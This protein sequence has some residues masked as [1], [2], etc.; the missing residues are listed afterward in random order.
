MKRR[1]FLHS[2]N[3][4]ALSSAIHGKAIYAQDSRDGKIVTVLGPIDPAALGTTLPHEHV[5]VDF[6]G[7]DQISEGRYDR[8]EAFDVILP[9][10]NEAK[11]H[12]LRALFECTPAYLGRDPIL[13]RRLAKASGLHL[14][15]NTGY[16]AAMK[17]K[18]M[19]AHAHKETADQLAARWIQEWEKGIENTGVFPGFIKIGVET[20][21]LSIMDKKLVHA[22]AKTSRATGMTIAAHTG[23]AAAMEELEIL[24]EEGVHPSAWIWVHANR[25]DQKDVRRAAEKGAWISFDKISPQSIADHVNLVKDMKDDGYLSRVMI[26]HDAGWYTPGEPRGGNYRGYNTVFEEFIPALKSAGLSEEDIHQIMVTTP[27]N[28]F[29][30][31]KQLHPT[32]T[33]KDL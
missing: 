21:P 31:H 1:T 18:F 24:E 4:L 6:I 29:T 33:K 15:T 32:G 14:V 30:I 5:L 9:Y 8:D 27:A 3:L 25:G 7:A 13:L 12:G 26:S 28:A 22:A 17:E 2:L 11:G 10:L 19:P 20:K 23:N 16:Y